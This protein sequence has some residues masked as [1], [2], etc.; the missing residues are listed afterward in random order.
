MIISV[1]D[2]TKYTPLTGGIGFG[3]VYNFKSVL[4]CHEAYSRFQRYTKMLFCLHISVLTWVRFGVTSGAELSFCCRKVGYAI[5]YAQLVDSTPA[6]WH[7]A[8]SGQP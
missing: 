5:H 7:S 8:N 6:I 2:D 1:H 4:I 3:F